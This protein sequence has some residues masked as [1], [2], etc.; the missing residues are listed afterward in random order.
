MVYELRH[1]FKPF[2]STP[3]I[4]EQRVVYRKRIVRFCLNLHAHM[5]IRALEGCLKRIEAYSVELQ[6]GDPFEYKNFVVVVT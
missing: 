3:K 4:R 2:L 5:K 1:E 6:E